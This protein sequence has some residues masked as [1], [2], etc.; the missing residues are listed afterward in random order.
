MN[1]EELA[2]ELEASEAE[3]KKKPPVPSPCAPTW[4][5]E[6]AAAAYFGMTRRQLM[7]RFRRHRLPAEARKIDHGS[8]W[9][10]VGAIIAHI[11]GL[12]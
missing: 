4:M 11:E 7:M 8:A 3:T 5:T 9:V 2:R 6:A 10:N 1:L 12:P